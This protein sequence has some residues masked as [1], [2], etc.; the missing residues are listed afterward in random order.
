[1]SRL[2]TL[3]VYSTVHPGVLPFLN[4]WRHSLD[5]QVDPDFVLCIG[6]DGLDAKSVP[7]LRDLGREVIWVEADGDTP[8]SLRERA[9]ALIVERF[10]GCVAV[11]ADDEL[12]PLRV[13]AARRAL[14]EADVTACG[15]ELI[16]ESGASLGQSMRSLYGHSVEQLL[17]RYNIFGLSNTVWSA[18]TLRAVM[19]FPAETILLDWYMATLAL[20]RGHVL[21]FDPT[22]HMRYRQHAAN[23][24]GVTPPFTADRVLAAARLVQQHFELLLPRVPEHWGGRLAVSSRAAEVTRF[25]KVM[26]SCPDLLAKYTLALNDV[27][28]EFVWWATIARPELEQLWKQ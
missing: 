2:P 3:A 12:L 26:A 28:L 9:F 22:C 15:L 7:A 13:S 25:V 27:D 17:L 23:T 11:D 6:V 21:R 19:P 8:T 24:A 14:Q 18:R 10:D 4:A 20:A 1:V 16:D 5:A